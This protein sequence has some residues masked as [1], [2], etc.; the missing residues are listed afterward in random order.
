VAAFA[1]ANSPSKIPNVTT[2]RTASSLQSVNYRGKTKPLLPRFR[3]GRLF[4]QQSV[5]NS[6]G[7][8]LRNHPYGNRAPTFVAR[9]PLVRDEI[10]I[11]AVQKF[12]SVRLDLL[13]H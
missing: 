11:I 8:E 9:L 3:N 4:T 13:C 10:C 6:A 5:G 1:A 12:V 2:T 7:N